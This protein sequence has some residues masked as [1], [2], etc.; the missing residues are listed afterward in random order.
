MLPLRQTAEQFLRNSSLFCPTTAPL[1][2]FQSIP[3][4]LESFGFLQNYSI[5]ISADS[6]ISLHFSSL[7]SSQGPCRFAL[8]PLRQTT[9]R[10]SLK[11][12]PPCLVLTRPV[13][14][15]SFS[16]FVR[17]CFRFG[18][19]LQICLTHEAATFSIAPRLS[20]KSVGGLKWTRTTD[21]TLIRRAL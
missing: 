19:L 10:I 11:F 20:C 6:L 16:S 8:L 1:F 5:C 4:M 21:L 17:L 7:F 15:L 13:E 2:R 18:Q 12:F 14:S 9:G 3:I